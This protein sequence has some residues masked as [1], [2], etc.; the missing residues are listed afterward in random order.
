MTTARR[1]KGAPAPRGARQAP[2]VA[3]SRPAEKTVPIQVWVRPSIAEAF[4]ERAGVDFG[5]KK[6]SKS[7]LFLA[8]WERYNRPI[9]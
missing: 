3:D 9:R 4:G 6:G 5:F 7:Q 2:I 8:M 1:R